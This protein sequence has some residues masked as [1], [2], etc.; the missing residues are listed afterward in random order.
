MLEDVGKKYC[1]DEARLFATG[2]SMG[3]SFSTFLACS[4]PG[5]VLGVA[6][7]E[8]AD[9]GGDY[10]CPATAA[11]ITHGTADTVIGTMTGPKWVKLWRASNNCGEPSLAF[12]TNGCIAYSACAKPVAYCEGP[13]GHE[14]PSFSSSTILEFFTSLL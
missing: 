6:P 10:T 1:I 2:F 7:V 8:A 14:W 5:K 13:W 4:G 9:P 12:G 11:L 3:A